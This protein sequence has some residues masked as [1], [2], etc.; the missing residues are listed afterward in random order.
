M[1][2]KSG[3]TSQFAAAVLL[4]V[5][6][7]AMIFSGMLFAFSLWVIASPATLSSAIEKLDSPVLKTLLAP[8]AL[9]VSL[10]VALAV[11]ALFFFFVSFM[12]FYGAITKS[13][14]LLFMLVASLPDRHLRVAGCD[15][16]SAVVL[17]APAPRSLAQL[18]TTAPRQRRAPKLQKA[19]VA[20]VARIPCAC[21]RRRAHASSR[22]RPPRL[23]R[24]E[25]VT[26]D[27]D[28][29]IK[30][31]CHVY[32]LRHKQGVL[33]LVQGLGNLD[34]VNQKTSQLTRMTQSK[35][36]VACVTCASKQDVLVLVRRLG[37]L[38]WV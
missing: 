8:Q 19:V 9:S 15:S 2:G 5:N 29:T 34:W 16:H 24:P 32:H 17:L 1:G 38:G 37:H 27:T 26:I 35:H 3:R 14:F 21:A 6:F 10:G 33:V 4:A 22:P 28:D 18:A 11:L 7:T 25:D 12:G 30:T 36:N 23:D 31:Q 13:Q 20:R